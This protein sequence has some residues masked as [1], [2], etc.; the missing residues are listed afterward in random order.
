MF[1]VLYQIIFLIISSFI[2]LQLQAQVSDCNNAIFFQDSLGEIPTPNGKGKI[3][4]ISGFSIK[5]EYFF[6]KEHNTVWCI[7]TFTQDATFQFDLIPQYPA[8]DFDFTILPYHGTKTCDSI[9][10][11]QLMPIRSNLA[12]RSPESGS[13]TGLS[14]KNSNFFSAAGPNPSFSAPIE[15][16]KGDSI[17]IIFDSPYGS[18]GGF[19]INNTSN[20]RPEEIEKVA[21]VIEAP[22]LK[23][24]TMIVVDE[25]ETPITNPSIYV[26]SLGKTHRDNPQIDENGNVYSEFFKSGVD[27]LVIA[28]QKGYLYQK[29]NFTWDGESDTTIFLKLT[30]LKPGTKLQLENILFISNSAEIV[31]KSKDELQD[32]LVFLKNNP[33]ME[34][35]IGGHVYGPKS[36]NINRYKKLSEE[37]ALAIYNFAITNG[38]DASRLTYKGYGNSEM[39]Y[40]PAVNETQIAANRRVEFT[41]TKVD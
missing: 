17:L 14:I 22:E 20:Y 12:K 16:L 29:F 32:L 27:Q 3:N 39:I 2:V 1:S 31:A 7:V 34:I 41:I 18:K 6:T 25:N 8:D 38:I 30:P 40:R 26:K 9:V 11:K 19:T 35:E 33:S 21:E 23:R 28:S 24:V 36:R 5:N 13:K 37:R 4:E 10:K 15:V